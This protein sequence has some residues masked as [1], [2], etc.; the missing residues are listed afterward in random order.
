MWSR[1]LQRPSRMSHELRKAS[2]RDRAG[3]LSYMSL[4]KGE[5][6]RARIAAMAC[7][8]REARIV[9]MA[10]IISNLRAIA[11]SP[12]AGL[13]SPQHPDCELRGDCSALPKPAPV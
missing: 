13:V 4:P 1:I 2:R 12:P 3:E 7:K 9:K 6:R 5:R 11:V 10:D 8:S